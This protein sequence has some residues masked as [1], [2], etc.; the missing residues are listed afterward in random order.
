MAANSSSTSV[1]TSRTIWSSLSTSP[2]STRAAT[3]LG[4]SRVSVSSTMR[5][6]SRS[7]CCKRQLTL[8][9]FTVSDR[10]SRL[11]FITFPLE[12]A[13][14]AGQLPCSSES[15]R[16]GWPMAPG[17]QSQRHGQP[18]SFQTAPFPPTSGGQV[19][20]PRPPLRDGPCGHR[21]RTRPRLPRQTQA[22]QS[23]HRRS[24]SDWALPTLQ[25]PAQA[26]PPPLWRR[27]QHPGCA[28]RDPFPKHR[29]EYLHVLPP[30]LS[31]AGML[32]QVERLTDRGQAFVHLIFCRSLP[33]NK[34]I[35]GSL[36]LHDL[37]FGNVPFE[38]PLA[39]GAR[40]FRPEVTRS[41]IRN[42]RNNIQRTR[43]VQATHNV[44]DLESHFLP[45]AA[46]SRARASRVAGVSRI[47]LMIS[48]ASSR[49]DSDGTGKRTSSEPAAESSCK[50]SS[51]SPPR[52]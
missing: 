39:E 31:V 24:R 4:Q 41:T 1:A 14:L 13:R 50:M 18:D 3:P 7:A 33:P 2:S 17:R 34:N 15:V 16:P 26:R 11:R 9:S 20:S 48:S 45:R 38:V 51:A 23:A 36:P 37:A 27:A 42:A 43:A 8:R 49:S 25:R 46:R 30:I 21:K 10:V 12:W 29:L 44:T 28:R 35:N 47:V 40:G 19:R 6:S 52:D 32:E 22:R 5:S